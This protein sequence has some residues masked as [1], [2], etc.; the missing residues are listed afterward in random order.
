[1]ANYVYIFVF[2]FRT[3]LFI[4]KNYKIAAFKIQFGNVVYD[5]RKNNVIAEKQNQNKRWKGAGTKILIDIK[6][7][8]KILYEKMPLHALRNYK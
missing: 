2:T 5:K 6:K 7:E 8:L 3:I 1:M 4:P